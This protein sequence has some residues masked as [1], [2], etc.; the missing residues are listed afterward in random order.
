M[1]PPP[2]PSSAP[3]AS[4]AE[5]LVPAGLL[6]LT[7][8]PVLGGIVRLISLSSG[9]AITPANARFVASPLPFLIHMIGATLFCILGAFQFV[10]GFRRRRPGWHRA[11]G[12]VLMVC[13][14]AAGLTGVWMTL[15]YAVPPEQQGILLYGFRLVIGAAMVLSIWRSWTAILKRD[16]PQ[17]RAWMMR[18]YAIGQG[19]GT[20]A[21][22]MIPAAILLGNVSGLPRDLLMIAAWVINLAIVELIL[23]RP[24]ANPR[25]PISAGDFGSR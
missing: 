14:L 2:S 10:P 3:R 25:R 23:R 21:L 18:G 11:A 4:K 22:I 7:I 20:Q 1:S 9:A 24:A 5:W 16:I 15:F 13:G 6:A 12:R 17:H 8:I 19:A